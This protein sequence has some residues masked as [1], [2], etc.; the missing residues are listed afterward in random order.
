M[1][2]DILVPGLDAVFVGTVVGRKS[3]EKGHYYSDPTNRFWPRLQQ[4][5][6]TPT[7]LGP[8]DD[9]VLP[10]FGLGLTDLNK[11]DAS[12]KDDVPF[13][14]ADFDLRIR[15]VA[16]SWVVFNGRRPAAEYAAWRGLAEPSYGFLNWTIGDSLV[17]VVPNS[18]GNNWDGRMLGGKTTVEWWQEA[19]QHIAQ[20]RGG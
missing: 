18:S 9:Q 17:F 2:P 14:P 5:G 10:A 6:L 15:A 4:A 1:L 3:A 13:Y 7:R 8:E 19:G 11:V 20:T 12:S 16:P